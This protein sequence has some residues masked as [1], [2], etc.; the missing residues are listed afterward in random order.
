MGI[1]DKIMSDNPLVQLLRNYRTSHVGYDY[2]M[3][4]TE[5]CVLTYDAWKEQVLGIPHNSF[6]VAA[7]FDPKKMSEAHKLD[8]EVILLRVIGPSPLS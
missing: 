5:V 4:F 3:N 6:L 7:A 1:T 2:S 8:Q